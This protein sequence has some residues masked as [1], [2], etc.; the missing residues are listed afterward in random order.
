MKK[1]LML[2]LIISL[3]LTACTQT[4]P[5]TEEISEGQPTEEETVLITSNKPAPPKYTSYVDGIDEASIEIIKHEASY[6]YDISDPFELK[7]DT[8]HV[9][10]GTIDS[11]DG[12][13]NTIGTGSFTLIPRTYG[14]LT[15]LQ[16]I[17][18]SFDSDTI[19]YA[20]YGGVISLADHEKDMPEDM[21]KNDQLHRTASGQENIDKENTYYDFLMAEDIHL[22]AGKTYLFYGSFYEGT[23]IFLIKGQQ[24]GTREVM[25]QA[26]GISSFREL[27]DTSRLSLK[28]NETGE[29]ESLD[30]YLR[31]YF[32]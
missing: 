20:K 8:D 9:F 16:E 26:S 24:Y 4:A 7:K 27:P 10:I 25:E 1:I 31:R 3:L 5:T 29:Y 28:N 32:N 15:V 13:S 18:G 22:E 2:G 17:M 23:D 6:E 12:A 14:K 21:R 19:T 30:E 11:I